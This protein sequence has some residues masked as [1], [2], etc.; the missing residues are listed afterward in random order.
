MEIAPGFPVSVPVRDSK[1][2][3]GPVLVVSRHAWAAFTEGLRAP[4]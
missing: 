3:D 2:P 1:T 4:R